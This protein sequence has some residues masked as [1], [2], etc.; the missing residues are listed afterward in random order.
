MS[1]YGIDVAF[2]CPVAGLTSNRTEA[3]ITAEFERL[4]RYVR[5]TKVYLETY[6]AGR[7]IERDKMI[8]LK[9]YFVGQGVKVSGG[10]TFTHGNRSTNLLQ[11]GFGTFCYTDPDSQRTVREIVEFTANLF[12][13]I[14]LDDFYFT[15]CRCDKCRSAKGE[16]SWID[17]RLRLMRQIAWWIQSLHR[18][19]D[20]LWRRPPTC[21]RSSETP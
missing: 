9:Q 5:F 17:Y 3:Q 10:I 13:E 19:Q 16:L 12:D 7:L 18:L 4:A 6:R 14:I 2:Y 1:H 8:R 15:S 21:S 11:G 20:T